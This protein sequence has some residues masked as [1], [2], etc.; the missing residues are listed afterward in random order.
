VSRWLSLTGRS[1]YSNRTRSGPPSCMVLRPRSHRKCSKWC[2]FRHHHLRPNHHT[3]T[4][5]VT[6]DKLTK[7]MAVNIRTMQMM[8]ETKIIQMGSKKRVTSGPSEGASANSRTI[9]SSKL[10]RHLFSKIPIGKKLR[11][12]V[13]MTCNHLSKIGKNREQSRGELGGKAR[14]MPWI[15]ASCWLLPTLRRDQK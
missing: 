15:I 9:N 3:R 6:N 4:G 13:A 10:R 14:R 7:T 2:H 5:T 12:T 1:K 11:S 8:T